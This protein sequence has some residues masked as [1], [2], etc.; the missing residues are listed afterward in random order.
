MLN[1]SILDGWWPEGFN[2][3][4][5]WAIGEESTSA[6]AE[7][8][9]ARDAELLYELLE[10]EVVPR[11]Y[12]RDEYGLPREWIGIMKVSI[13]SLTPMFSARRMVKEYCTRM[14]ATAW[15]NGQQPKYG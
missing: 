12:R 11:Y 10:N 15:A 8:Q 14:Y 1:V 9:D 4:N 7:A 13:A 5:G 3:R 6:D 2:G